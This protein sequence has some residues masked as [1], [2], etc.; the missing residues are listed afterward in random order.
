LRGVQEDTL[1]LCMQHVIS[2]HIPLAQKLNMRCDMFNIPVLV[3]P[4]P[5]PFLQLDLT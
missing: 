1:V 3:Q 5:F 4:L 2:S